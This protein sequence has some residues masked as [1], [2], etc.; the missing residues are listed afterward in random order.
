MTSAY[1]ADVRTLGGALAERIADRR[2][3]LGEECT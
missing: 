3:L 2:G 1:V